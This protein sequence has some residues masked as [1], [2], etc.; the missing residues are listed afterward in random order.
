MSIKS[1]KKDMRMAMLDQLKQNPNKNE[2]EDAIIHTFINEDVF[3]NAN[4]I[5]ITMSMDHELDTRWLIDYAVGHGK[6]VYVPY[7]DYNT[8]QMHFVRYTSDEDITQ[9]AFGIDIMNHKQEAG[10]HPELL[11]VPGVI[12]NEVG[13]RI[14]YGGGYFDKFLS[15]YKGHTVSLIF[16]FQLAEVLIEDHDI[17]VQ[18]LITEERTIHD[19]VSR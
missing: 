10:T 6:K 4:S 14:G 3:K 15:Q 18:M 8:K 5:G 17:P 12:F 19:E 16:E 7:C 13:Y 9:D 1:E 2:K 11:V